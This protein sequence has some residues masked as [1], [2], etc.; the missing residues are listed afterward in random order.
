MR[1]GRI[2]TSVKPPH[3]TFSNEPKRY[4]ISLQENKSTNATLLSQY[5]CFNENNS[6]QINVYSMNGQLYHSVQNTYKGI[7]GFE[8]LVS[9]LKAGYY[10]IQSGQLVTS[11]LIIP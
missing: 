1:A 11:L 2:L 10:V 6:A 4:I 8:A 3:N 5:K 9:S 7:E